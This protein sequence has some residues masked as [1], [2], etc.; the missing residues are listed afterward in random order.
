[1]SE[2]LTEG[3][4]ELLGDLEAEFNAARLEK[5]GTYAVAA[6]RITALVYQEAVQ[7][8]LPVPVAQGMAQDFWMAVVGLPA[9]LVDEDDDE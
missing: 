3:F 7:G 2:G 1:M 9:A 5:R 6:A 8:G 4:N